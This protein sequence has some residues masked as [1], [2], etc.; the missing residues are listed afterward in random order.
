MRNLFKVNYIPKK[1]HSRAFVNYEKVS[2]R[3]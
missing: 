1:S 3:V 2:Q